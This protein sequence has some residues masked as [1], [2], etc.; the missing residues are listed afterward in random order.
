MRE[1]SNSYARHLISSSLGGMH[2]QKVCVIIEE[3]NRVSTQ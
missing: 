2:A 3:Q 1:R